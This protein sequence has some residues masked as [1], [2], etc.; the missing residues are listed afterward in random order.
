MNIDAQWVLKRAALLADFNINK[1][2]VVNEEGVAFFDFTDA[3]DDDWYCISEYTVDHIWKGAGEMAYEVER[4]KLKPHCKL[5]ALKLVGQ[6]TSVGAFTE[7][8]NHTGVVGFTQL[9]TGDFK[10]ARAEMLADDEC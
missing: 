4:I 1:F 3:T 8:I 5:Q 2:T 6:C 10:A 9:S 7:N